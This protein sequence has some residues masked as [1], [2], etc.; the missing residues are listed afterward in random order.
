[1]GV[2]YSAVGGFGYKISPD[3]SK[4]LW[5]TFGV[6]CFEKGRQLELPDSVEESTYGNYFWENNIGTLITIACDLSAILRGEATLPDVSPID[7]WAK[8][9]N[10]VFEN[11][12]PELF[13]EYCVS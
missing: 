1:M 2:D 7:E 8:K 9:H 13:L 6:E 4:E 11:T 12:R 3:V 5:D 10:I